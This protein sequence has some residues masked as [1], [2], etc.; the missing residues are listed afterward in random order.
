MATTHQILLVI[1]LCTPALVTVTLLA[2][3]CHRKRAEN[4]R[5]EAILAARARIA[6]YEARQRARWEA[7]RA[8]QIEGE[9]IRTLA[10]LEGLVP[11]RVATDRSGY[12][13]PLPAPLTSQSRQHRSEPIHSQR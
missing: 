11:E 4:K 9:R 2:I 13:A 5:A 3:W 6:T 7:V 1:L 10:A 8:W 12:R